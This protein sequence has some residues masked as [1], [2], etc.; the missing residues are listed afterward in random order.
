MHSINLSAQFSY[1][2]HLMNFRKPEWLFI[3]LNHFQ[4]EGRGA[5][6]LSKLYG[7]IFGTNNRERIA[8]SSFKADFNF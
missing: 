4:Q 1:F 6:K 2:S 7:F 3:Q 8:Y 5:R